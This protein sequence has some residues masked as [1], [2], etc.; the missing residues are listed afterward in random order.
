MPLHR[1]VSNEVFII[2]L[3]CGMPWGQLLR[4]AYSVTS[5]LRGK[6]LDVRT[7]EC[8]SLSVAFRVNSDFLEVPV[9]E[10]YVHPPE[11]TAT[12]TIIMPDVLYTFVYVN[13]RAHVCVMFVIHLLC[14]LLCKPT[15]TTHMATE[16]VASVLSVLDKLH[17]KAPECSELEDA[18]KIMQMASA[19]EVARYKPETALL[20]AFAAKGAAVRAGLAL[21][22]EEA[23]GFV[24]LAAR[25][26][27]AA[28]SNPRLHATEAFMQLQEDSV[29]FDA[30]QPLSTVITSDSR[31]ATK[32]IQNVL[33]VEL[34][35]KVQWVIYKDAGQQVDNPSQGLCLWKWSMLREEGR[36][37]R[38]RIRKYMALFP[39]WPLLCAIWHLRTGR[40]RVWF[41]S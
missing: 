19:A 28:L 25:W 23:S 38:R 6:V 3:L 16:A 41:Q 1:I 18:L 15:Y 29:A 30:E 12:A 22:D 31:K 24:H 9:P 37:H 32:V 2:S 21:Q 36:Q 14:A 5:V 4:S 39:G 10:T 20:A 34:A 13:L 17:G 8:S 26:F 33:R 11:R 40:R 7:A 27:A 35:R